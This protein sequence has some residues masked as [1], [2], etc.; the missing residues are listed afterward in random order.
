[1]WTDDLVAETVERWNGGQSA[2]EI[3]LEIS[4]TYGNRFSRESVI[5]KIHRLRVKGVTLR[6]GQQQLKLR[7]NQK[8]PARLPKDPMPTMDLDFEPLVDSITDLEQEQC[9]YMHGDSKEGK[10]CGRNTV[11]GSSWCQR[12]YDR[13]WLSKD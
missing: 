3:S 8:K 13:I 4:E 6:A 5:A 10:Y 9:R 2:S 12:H 7:P 11:Q 1:M